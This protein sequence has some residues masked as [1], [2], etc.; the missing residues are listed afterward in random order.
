MKRTFVKGMLDARTE[1][2]QGSKATFVTLKK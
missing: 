2:Q 1:Q